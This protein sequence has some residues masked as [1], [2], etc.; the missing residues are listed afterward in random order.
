M[1]YEDSGYYDSG[2]YEGWLGSPDA[3]QSQAAQVIQQTA[4]PVVT[5]APANDSSE[6]IKGMIDRQRAS[7]MTDAALAELWSGQPLATQYLNGATA[8]AEALQ[9]YLDAAWA[10]QNPVVETPVTQAPT[11]AAIPTAAPTPVAAPA[12]PVDPTAG[13]TFEPTSGMWGTY[14]QGY[15]ENDYQPIFA[16]AAVQPTGG[17]LTQSTVNTGSVREPTTSTVYKWNAGEDPAVTA[18]YARGT[19]AGNI[20]GLNYDQFAKA[21]APYGGPNSSVSND[22]GD[23]PTFQLAAN[24]FGKTDTA[25][26]PGG[27]GGGA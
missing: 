15:R 13:L 25:W 9:P 1:S 22:N 8:S 19:T 3:M 6:V 27:A 21:M 18:A 20:W 4:T 12:P 24:P 26:Q 7:G 16:P 23:M 14:T 11:V 10:K 17:Y 5:A 2:D